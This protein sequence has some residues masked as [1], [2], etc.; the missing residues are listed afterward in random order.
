MK[1]LTDNLSAKNLADEFFQNKQGIEASEL[2]NKEILVELTRL[3]E[4]DSALIGNHK[5]GYVERKGS[6]S[7]ASVVKDHLPGLD[8]ESYRGKPSGFFQLK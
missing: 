4:G 8:L 3:S 5:L 7:Y 6:V 1:N 2:R